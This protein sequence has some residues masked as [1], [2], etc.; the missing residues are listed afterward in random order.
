LQL[1]WMHT[2]SFHVLNEDVVKRLE[3]NRVELHRC[4]HVVCGR[5]NIRITEHEKCTYRG[6]RDELHLCSEHEDTGAFCTDQ[7]SCYVEVLFGK[8]RRKVVPGNASWNHL[9][10]GPDILGKTIA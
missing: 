6:I 3:S 9:E 2:F 1:R 10:L 7:C 4:H 8:E 5:E